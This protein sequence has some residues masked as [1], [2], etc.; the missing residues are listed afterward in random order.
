MTLQDLYKLVDNASEELVRNCLKEILQHW[1][2]DIG[3]GTVNPEK[4]L[5]PD[6]I[7]AVAGLL[8]YCGFC[9]NPDECK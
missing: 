7:M 4:E 2:G 9:P 8:Q 6:T 5:G 3:D 1:F